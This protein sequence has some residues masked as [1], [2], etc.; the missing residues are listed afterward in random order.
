MND[1]LLLL[2]LWVILWK[3]TEWMFPTASQLV[4]RLGRWAWREI[5]SLLWRT[6]VRHFGVFATLALWWSGLMVLVLARATLYASSP[7]LLG[8][9]VVAGLLV[10]LVA[11]WWVARWRA[12]RRYRVRPL[13]ARRRR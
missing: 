7:L 11:V 1:L 4:R 6:P 13:P 2:M 9:G 5:A 12:Q 8:T 3:Y 10:L